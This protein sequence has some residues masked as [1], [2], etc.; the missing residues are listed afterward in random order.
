MTVLP[1]TL[2]LRLVGAATVVA[3]VVEVVVLV[4]DVVGGRLLDVEL[5]VDV[6]EVVAGKLLEVEVVEVL[7]VEVVDPLARGTT[8]KVTL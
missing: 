6:L 7:V 2:A 4:V 8:N 5:V 1:E 3:M